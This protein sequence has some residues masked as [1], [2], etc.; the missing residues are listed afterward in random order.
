MTQRI[1]RHLQIVETNN[2]FFRNEQ[3]GNRAVV[4]TIIV[5]QGI[6][7]LTLL[8]NL[9]GVFSGRALTM[10]AIKGIIFQMFPLAVYAVFGPGK[11]WMKYVLLISM[12]LCMA[13]VDAEL[14]YMTAL[15]MA[16]PVVISIRYFSAKTT[17]RVAVFTAIAFAGSAIWGAT[18]GILDVNV[19]DIPQGSTLFIETRLVTAL[20]EM[21]LADS[22]LIRNTLLF[23]YVPRLFLF[24]IIA[25]ASIQ[26][27]ARSHKMI[28]E[29]QYISRVDAEL[30]MASEIQQS[31]LPDPLTTFSERTDFDIYATMTPAR[32]IGGD[33]YDFFMVDDDHLCLLIADVSD[34]GVPAA[35]F[36]MSSQSMIK[37]EAMKG[38]SPGK[39]LESVNKQ[40]CVNNPKN[41]FVTVWLGLLE[42]SSGKM[43]CVN[44]GHEYPIIKQ[45]GGAFEIFKDK[46]GLVVGAMDIAKYREYDLS[47][48]PG[49]KLFVYTDGLAEA[50]GEEKEQFGLDRVVDVLNRNPDGSPQ[51]LLDTVTN[52]VDVFVHGA[53]QFDDLTMLC[54]EYCGLDKI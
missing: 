26:S 6:F 27:A 10:A 19:I 34:K 5:T 39:V 23:R 49:S 16:I 14:T 37:S 21:G 48:K 9:L 1:E 13:I 50:I 29:Q 42:L 25:Y 2:V 18:N 8:L 3:Q 28:R 30:S 12:V 24:V 52:E 17:F 4:L 20:Q 22:M 38:S 7:L 40:I 33:Y 46:H 11:P 45:P 53:E 36:M 54:L 32:E 51:E 15:L 31:H 44:A 47:L 35:L 43:K 41:M